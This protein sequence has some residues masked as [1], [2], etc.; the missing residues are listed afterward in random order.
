MNDSL[1]HQALQYDLHISPPPSEDES[2]RSISRGTPISPS[3]TH[4]YSSTDNRFTRPRPTAHLAA[5][6][7]E[8]DGQSW[9]EQ[10]LL[11]APSPPLHPA[12]PPRLSAPKDE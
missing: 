11:S 3:S 6:R 8:Y 1:S 5:S 9:A 4:R 2:T 12:E 10:P 7:H